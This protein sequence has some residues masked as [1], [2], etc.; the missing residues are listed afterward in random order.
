M[1]TTICI[2]G[3]VA[4]TA[5]CLVAYLARGQHKPKTNSDWERRLAVLPI[6]AYDLSQ[7]KHDTVRVEPPKNRRPEPESPFGN[8]MRLA[9][10]N[11]W[12]LVHHSDCHYQ[13]VRIEGQK[14]IYNLYPTTGKIH[15]D[16]HYKGP[17][18]NLYRKNWT[19]MDAVEAIIAAGKRGQVTP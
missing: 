1:T 17:H 4:F 10:Q 6:C 8:A 5:G 12:A 14:Q 16:P 13:M 7:E 11:G 15:I 19:L 9:A 2:V 18:V 3:V